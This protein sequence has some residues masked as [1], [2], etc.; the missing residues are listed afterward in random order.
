MSSS[1]RQRQSK[2]LRT[3]CAS[4]RARKALFKYRGEVRAD[5]DHTLCFECYRA[6]LNRARAKRLKEPPAQ[7]QSVSSLGHDDGVGSR[8]GSDRQVA[9][10]QRMLDH[11]RRR[12][13]MA[14]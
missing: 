12:S 1:E 14:S 4:C 9:H 5:R 3:S 8:I 10:R 6:E 11:L 7:R 2:R 13:E